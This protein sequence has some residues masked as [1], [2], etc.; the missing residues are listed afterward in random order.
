MDTVAREKS[1]TLPLEI[2]ALIKNSIPCC[3]REKLK[4]LR[5]VVLPPNMFISLTS[6]ASTNSRKV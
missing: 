4:L 6:L 1:D 3:K 5:D 2:I